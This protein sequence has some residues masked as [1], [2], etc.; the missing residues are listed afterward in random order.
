MSVWDAASGDKDSVGMEEAIGAKNVADRFISAWD[1]SS[2]LGD[3]SQKQTTEVRQMYSLPSLTSQL[4]RVLAWGSLVA[5][6]P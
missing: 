6:A 3:D 4:A 1:A 5:P 2:R